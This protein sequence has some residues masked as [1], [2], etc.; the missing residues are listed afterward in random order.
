MA[1]DIGQQSRDYQRMEAA[2]EW[3]AQSDHAQANLDEAAAVVNMSPF[4]FQRLFTR[5]AGI[6]PK[7]F[8]HNV[9]LVRAKESLDQGASVFEAALDSGLSGPGRLH[10]LFVNIEAVSPGEYKQGLAGTC[11]QYGYHPTPFGECLIMTTARGICAF[12][13]CQREQSPAHL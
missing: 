2:L 7:Q 4:H 12:G 8:L 6:S 5:W 11:I 1:T 9:S 13:F 10:D 3:L